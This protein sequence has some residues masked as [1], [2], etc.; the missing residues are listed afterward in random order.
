[1]EPKDYGIG[2]YDL[3]KIFG[4]ANMEFK[5]IEEQITKEMAKMNEIKPIHF[6]NP[7][8]L[9]GIY[10][11]NG[12]T[13][14]VTFI[15]RELK[16]QHDNWTWTVTDVK[17][18]NRVANTLSILKYPKLNGYATMI[19]YSYGQETQ[20]EIKRDKLNDI[21]FLKSQLLTLADLPF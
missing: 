10:Q 3:Y 1:M 19:R 17:Y 5:D 18:P 20:E 6:N 21:E 14:K 15:G 12:N 16:L 4:L 13:F 9:N 7:E 11:H 8:K 2:V